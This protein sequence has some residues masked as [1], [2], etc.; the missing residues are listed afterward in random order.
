MKTIYQSIILVGLMICFWILPAEAANGKGSS[1]AQQ[2]KLTVS[3]VQVTQI[4]ATQAKCSFTVQGSP[5]SE[6][7]VCYSDGPSPT[8][9]SKKSMAPGNPTNTGISMLSGLKANTKYYVR[10][11]AKSGSEVLYGNEQNFTTAAQEQSKSTNQNT[12]QKVESKT[13]GSK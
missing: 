6:K 8:I 5:I 2:G 4:K 13:G 1:S 12:G 7:G 10:A 9:S 3:A 11:Y